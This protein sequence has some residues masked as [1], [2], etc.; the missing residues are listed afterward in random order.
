MVESIEKPRALREK[1]FV[2]M[3]FNDLV[4]SAF[5]EGIALAIEETG[6]R[7]I[8]IDLQEHSESVI[9]RIVAEIR[10]ARFVV[11]D[12]TGNRGGVYFEAGFARGLGLDVIWTCK[13][14]HF[15]EVHF[16][17]RGFN[18]IVWKMA[19]DLRERLQARI[20]AVIGYGPLHDPSRPS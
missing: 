13:E 8:R 19:T 4:R 17:V 20:R 1:A 7:A 15:K 2:A 11:A 14:D 10:E 16:D 5:H 12:F 6:Y 3:W 9:D 18:V